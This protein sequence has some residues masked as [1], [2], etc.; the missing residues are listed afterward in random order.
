M[1]L[2]AA[3]PALER[4]VQVKARTP[5]RFFLNYCTFGYTMSW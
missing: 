2:P 4:P 5:N 3:L 1:E